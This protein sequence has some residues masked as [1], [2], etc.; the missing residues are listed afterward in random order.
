MCTGKRSRSRFNSERT[1]NQT[2]H[3]GMKHL[4]INKTICV[5]EFF[6]TVTH[7]ALD[8]IH[9]FAYL[10]CPNQYGSFIN[11]KNHTS[12]VECVQKVL[13][14]KNIFITKSYIKISK[15]LTIKKEQSIA[16]QFERSPKY[17]ILI[18]SPFSLSW[19]L[20]NLPPAHGETFN[21]YAGAIFPKK[22]NNLF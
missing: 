6:G 22:R 1:F 19:H 11:Y 8:Q 5:L 12:K 14:G 21:H 10:P 7:Y 15:N 16:A 17:K 18:L 3:E 9:S 13:V 20:P 4:R 2:K